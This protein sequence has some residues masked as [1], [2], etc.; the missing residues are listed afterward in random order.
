MMVPV[1][2]SG[3]VAIRFINAVLPSVWL[4]GGLRLQSAPSPLPSSGVF[5]TFRGYSPG[6][7]LVMLSVCYLP[8]HVFA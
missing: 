2:L 6:K 4:F 5:G 1:T 8:S 7:F 3:D